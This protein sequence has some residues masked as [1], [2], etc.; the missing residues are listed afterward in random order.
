[1]QRFLNFL[2]GASV[3]AIVGATAAILLAPSS[4]EEL[5]IQIQERANTIRDDVKHAA[6]ERRAELEEQLSMMRSPQ[7]PP[8]VE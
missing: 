2:I 7:P 4:G 3:G 8:P 5:R 6:A 1:M